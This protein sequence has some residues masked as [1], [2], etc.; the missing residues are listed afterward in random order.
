MFAVRSGSPRQLCYDILSAADQNP[1]KLH[2]RPWNFHD[3]DASLWWLVPSGDWPAYKY[4]KLLCDWRYEN[5]G[6]LLCG[7]YVEKGLGA[8]VR[9]AY[10]TARAK[11]LFMDNSWCWMPFIA[12]LASGEIGTELAALEHNRTATWEIRIDCGFVEDPANFDPYSG[13]YRDASARY[14]WS[15]MPGTDPRAMAAISTDDLLGI[16]APLKRVTSVTELAN[17]FAKLPRYEWLWIDLTIGLPL[18]KN[19]DSTSTDL[20]S[21]Q[22]LWNWHLKPL[23]RWLSAAN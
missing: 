13:G 15:W 1:V 5:L 7:I 21:S 14:R 4:G 2:A 22:Q 23:A 19:S 6:D 3:P 16:A 9:A 10:P 11:P 8:E 17:T 18:L 20:R 12:A